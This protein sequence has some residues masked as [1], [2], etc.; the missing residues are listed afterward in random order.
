MPENIMSSS[1]SCQA[2][3]DPDPLGKNLWTIHQIIL[4]MNPGVCVLRIL[5]AFT[6]LVT[7]LA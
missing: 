5:L 2:P 3:G 4:G 7:V 1:P 6:M